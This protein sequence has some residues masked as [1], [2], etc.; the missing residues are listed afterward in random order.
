M[1]VVSAVE[2]RERPEL[3]NLDRTAPFYFSIAVLMRVCFVVLLVSTG[4]T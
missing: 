3:I 1:E 4:R 2:L